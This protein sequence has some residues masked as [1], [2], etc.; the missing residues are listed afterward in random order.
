[1]TIAE[2]T[3][4]FSQQAQAMELD[5]DKI[6]RAAGNN[7]V[8]A[9]ATKRLRAQFSLTRAYSAYFGQMV[10]ENARRKLEPVELYS[11]ALDFKEGLQPMFGRSG[12]TLE[13][14]RPT[15]YD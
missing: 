13:I 1:L 10:S 12:I 2:F 8:L 6:V 11:F 3:H 9:E 5:V 4:D 14:M 15:D 7:S